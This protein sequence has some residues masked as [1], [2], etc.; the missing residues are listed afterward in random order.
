MTEQTAEPEIRQRLLDS[1]ARVL[2]EEGSSALS[3]RRL[4]REAGTS[5][6][7]VYTYFGG[8]PGLVR[9][10]AEEGFARLAEHLAA[11]PRTEDSLEDLRGLGAA[12]R[13]SALANPHLYSVMFGSLAPDKPAAPGESGAEAEIGRYTFDVLIEGV[14]RIIDDAIV[15]AGSDAEHIAAQFWTAIHGYVML[16]LAGY[17][18]ESEG[19][20]ETV[21]WPMLTNLVMGLSMRP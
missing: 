15:S 16:E 9:A 1:A 10:V 14:E 8:M 6:M 12:Y 2:S 13:Q 19:D 4:A 7:A 11:V 5:T 17:H 3:A 18:R 21:L 20:T